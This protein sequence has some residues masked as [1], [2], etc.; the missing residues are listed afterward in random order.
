MKQHGGK[1]TEHEHEINKDILE[2][3]TYEFKNDDFES[4]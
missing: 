2:D 3:A 1:S 4:V